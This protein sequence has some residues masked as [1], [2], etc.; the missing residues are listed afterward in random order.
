MT[1]RSSSNFDVESKDVSRYLPFNFRIASNICAAVPTL[2]RFISSSWSGAGWAESARQVIMPGRNRVMTTGWDTLKIQWQIIC[3]MHYQ[4]KSL[5][6]LRKGGPLPQP[7]CQLQESSMLAQSQQYRSRFGK[8]FLE[9]I[10]KTKF[11]LWWF[12]FID[13][14][15]HHKTD[16]CTFIQFHWMVERANL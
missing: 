13:F 10:T 9:S 14:W 15:L 11:L 1:V 8:I 3:L 7:C 2:K 16:T 5:M 12:N 6:S 4:L